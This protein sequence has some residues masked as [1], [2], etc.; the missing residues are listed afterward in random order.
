MKI[1]SKSKLARRQKSG[2]NVK[3]KLDGT[4]RGRRIFF[5]ELPY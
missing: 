2:S 3:K 4:T 1:L 5:F